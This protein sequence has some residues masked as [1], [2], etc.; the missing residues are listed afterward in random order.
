MKTRQE[1]MAAR[2]KRVIVMESVPQLVVKVPYCSGLRLMEALRLRVKDSGLSDAPIDSARWQEGEEPLYR[3]DES[4]AI[5]VVRVRLEIKLVDVLLVEDERGG[6]KNVVSL[7]FHF[8]DSFRGEAF[9]AG[10]EV[11]LQNGRGG[12]DGEIAE[13][14]HLP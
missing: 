11:A 12:F 6:E 7:D 10:F 8:T 3:L 9:G 2:P 4:S 1:L 13:V 5:V 14:L